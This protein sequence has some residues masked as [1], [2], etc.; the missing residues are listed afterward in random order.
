MQTESDILIVGCGVVGL[1]AALSMQKRGFSVTLLDAGQ[2]TTNKAVEISRVYAINQASVDLFKKLDIWNYIDK[3]RSSPYSR[4]HV[5]DSVNTAH[6][7]FDS[8]IINSDKL[9]FMLEESVIKEALLKEISKVDINLIPE[10]QV[11]EVVE[12]TDNICVVDQKDIKRHAKLLIVA[13]GAR[14]TLREMLGVKVTTWPYYQQAIV[15]NVTTENPH[16]KTAYQVFQPNGPLAFLPMA[17]KNQSSI[18]WSTSPEHAKRLMELSTEEFEVELT[19]AFEDKLGHVRVFSKRHKFPLHMRHVNTYTGARWLLMGDAAHTIH[20]LAGLGLNVGLADLA[21]WIDELEN[22][23]C[24]LTSPRTLKSYQRKRKHALWTVIAL[25]QGLHVLFTNKLS[26][27][28][29]I[30]GFGLNLFNKLMPIKKI[31]IEHASGHKNYVSN[32]N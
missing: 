14:S 1:C 21:T 23:N 12:N 27:V 9:G 25:M 19:N 16:K 13:D 7:D 4:M 2:V 3:S 31:I 11:C 28:I 30:R 29:K 6:I 22:N 15:A 17:E 32:D 24:K 20:P 10:C 18:V 8:R 5:W 26:A